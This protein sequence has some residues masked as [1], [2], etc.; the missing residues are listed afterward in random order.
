MRNIILFDDESREQM[1]PLTY[2][3]PVAELRTGILTICERWEKLLRGTTS[4]ITSDYLGQRFPIRLEDDN[5][6]INGAVLPND[7]LVRVIEQLEQ[8]EA[9]MDKGVLIAARLNLAQFEKLFHDESIDEISGIDLADT[10]FIHLAYPWDLF[11]SLRTSIE[12]DYH[13]VTRGRTS[14]VIPSHNQVISPDNI[15]LEE[16]AKVTCAILNAQSGPIYIG[17]DAQVM[18]GAVLH[19]PVTIG[20]ESVV[21]MGARIYGPVAIGPDCKIGGEL[22]EVVI[23][24][25][26]NK[27]HDGFLGNSIIGE[28]C[29]LG[30]GT[31]VSNLKNNYSNVRTWDFTTQSMR[32]SGLQ[33]L[34]TVMGDHTK[35][36]IQ[37]MLNTG[38]TIGIAAN[39]FGEGF[40]PKFIPSFSWGG[41]S[42]ITTHR[43]ED[44]IDTARRVMARRRMEFSKDEEE[45]LRHVFNISKL[46]R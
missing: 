19:G 9:L 21:K 29:N 10:P 17:K 12:Y 36:G 18:E 39:I 45:I 5:I 3:R 14:Q 30:A 4:Y 20:D 2:T 22:K 13:L 37:T 44:A 16:G 34:G 28:W 15:F 42:G 32:D 35:T 26:S 1:L 33:F 23:M 40:P 24:G 41:A 6:V 11:L 43:L 27:A 25:H 8:N 38:T 31:T 7:R 46:D